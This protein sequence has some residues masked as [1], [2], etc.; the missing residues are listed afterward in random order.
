[1][2]LTAVPHAAQP[3]AVDESEMR[4]HLTSDVCKRALFREVTSG[5]KRHCN[6]LFVVLKDF[7]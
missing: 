1:M 6:G 4:R 5:L 7:T 3:S 2:R